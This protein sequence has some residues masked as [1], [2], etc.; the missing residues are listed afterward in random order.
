[1]NRFKFFHCF[2]LHHDTIFH[3]EVYSISA[4][5]LGTTVDERQSLLEFKRDFPLSQFK[6]E[7]SFIC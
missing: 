1:M 6:G 3:Q 2:Y 5:Q 4:I 7:T